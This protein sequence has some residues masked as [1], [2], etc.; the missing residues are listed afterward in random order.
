MIFD[1]ICS[2]LY[3]ITHHKYL[4]D[5]INL[6]HCIEILAKIL[7]SY[8]KLDTKTV[9]QYFTSVINLSDY[10]IGILL[11]C[12]AMSS[13][14]RSFG[15]EIKFNDVD[16]NNDSRYL[17]LACINYGIDKNISIMIKQLVSSFQVL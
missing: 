2:L 1:G 7:V 8:F 3:S 14:F 13:L 17:L 16:S 15:G 11:C 5:N 10:D 9:S 4:L 6:G 12:K